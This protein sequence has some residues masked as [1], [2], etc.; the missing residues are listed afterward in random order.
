VTSVS[1]RGPSMKIIRTDKER[2]GQENRIFPGDEDSTLTLMSTASAGSADTPAVPRRVAIYGAGGLGREV[3]MA[4]RMCGKGSTYDIVAFIDDDPELYGDE[5]EGVPVRH[6]KTVHD[7]FPEAKLFCA[8]SEPK[9]RLRSVDL[10]HALGYTF[11][12]FIHES[13]VL[14]PSISIGEGCIISAGCILTTDVTLGNFVIINLQ[15]TLG[16]DV[17]VGDYCTIGPGVRVGGYVNI[18]PRA[19]VNMGALIVNGSKTDPVIIGPDAMVGAGSCVITSV[20]AGSS[21]FGNPARNIPVSP[22]A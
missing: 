20:R 18:M 12:S 14:G 9:A 8:I 22:G 5:I 21:V 4:V 16:H 19:R 17:Q 13:A 1:Q 6:L 15:S 7:E 3:A 10:A 2:T 11:E